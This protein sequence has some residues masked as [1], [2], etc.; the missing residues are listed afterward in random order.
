MGVVAGHDEGLTPVLGRHRSVLN[1][2]GRVVVVAR[3]HREIRHVAVGAVG[4]LGAD[5]ELLCRPFAVEN[6]GRRIDLHLDHRRYGAGI[7]GR[8]RLEPADERG[9]VFVPLLDLPAATV[10]HGVDR[11][12]H[13][14]AFLGNGQIEP[15]AGK[16]PRE[17]VVIAVRIKPEQR[18]PKAVLA[19]GGAVTT[20]GVAAGTQEHRHD[21][22]PEAQGGILPGPLNMDGDRQRL[23]ADGHLERRVAVSEGTEHS[24]FH[25]HAIRVLDHERRLPRDI[26]S[27][28]VG[29]C[30]LDDHRLP[31]A[32]GGEMDRG[33]IDGEGLANSHR[34]DR[35]LGADAGPRRAGRHEEQRS[36]KRDD[37]GRDTQAR[38]D[39]ITNR[40]EAED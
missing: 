21:V 7:V 4:V 10:G 32:A 40:D 19:P 16:L 6:R 12:L 22:E 20:P 30:R 1:D 33:R 14:Q 13:Q 38:D 31:V 34:S 9:V 2:H 27:Y 23:L 18:Q 28:A 35:L 8:A 26:A 11:L 5:D 24:P 29:R 37:Q 17:A 25:R 36:Q 3:E 15:A 39:P